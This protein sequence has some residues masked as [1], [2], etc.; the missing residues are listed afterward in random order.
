MF[1][2]V[3]ARRLFDAGKGRN[4]IA[5]ALGVG[6]ATITR[7]ANREGLSFDR[8]ATEKAVKARVIDA[9]ARRISI[10]ERLYTRT[11]AVLTRL[12]AD[13]FTTLVRGAQGRE[14]QRTLAFVPPTHERELSSSMSN[15]LASAAK[16]EAID[17]GQDADDAKSM[18]AKLGRA[19]GIGEQE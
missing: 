8:T 3:E 4:E 7:W 15:Y 12:E 10:V 14:S 1:D 6:F 11:E 19:L 13:E 2:P 9:K 17:S 16:L 5:K 18:L